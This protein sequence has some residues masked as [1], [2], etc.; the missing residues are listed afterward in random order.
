MSFTG[1]QINASIVNENRK[2]HDCICDGAIGF[3]LHPERAHPQYKFSVGRSAPGLW[4]L[5]NPKVALFGMQN[6]FKI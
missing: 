4:N 1:M 5:H 2:L 3:N 6:L